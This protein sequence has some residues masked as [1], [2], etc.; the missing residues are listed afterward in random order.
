MK[1]KLLIMVIGAMMSIAGFAQN[2]FEM[3]AANQYSG[4]FISSEIRM[5]ICEENGSVKGNLFYDN[6]N[7]IYPITG[8]INN[9]ILKGYFNN[10]TDNF[11][12]ILRQRGGEYYF[13]AGSTTASMRKFEKIDFTNSWE[14]DNI[15]V[16][17]EK[18]GINEYGGILFFNGQK[19]FIKGIAN[20]ISITGTFSNGTESFP[21]TLIQSFRKNSIEFKTGTYSERLYLNGMNLENLGNGIVMLDVLPKNIEKKITSKYKLD[22]NGILTYI[23]FRENDTLP[24]NLKKILSGFSTEEGDYDT[25]WS[26]EEEDAWKER[27]KVAVNKL[28]QIFSNEGAIKMESKKYARLT[29]YFDNLT[30][31][32]SVNGEFYI[33]YMAIYKTGSEKKEE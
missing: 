3:K 8:E 29:V 12:F 19:Y 18:K 4:V 1:K 2:P 7:I 17:L 16:V 14:S 25:H 20:A 28:K 23:E 27:C 5:R 33:F 6:G 32:F 26:Q 9:S 21:L 10:G 13:K 30:F 31:E 24:E 22:G 11:S 15:K